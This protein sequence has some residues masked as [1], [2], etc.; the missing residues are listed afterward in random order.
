M[1]HQFICSSDVSEHL[2]EWRV[3]EALHSPSQ[4]VTCVRVSHDL[5]RNAGAQGPALEILS[6]Q[7]WGSVGDLDV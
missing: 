7:V 1:F 3:G 4:A 5:M 6:P 2:K